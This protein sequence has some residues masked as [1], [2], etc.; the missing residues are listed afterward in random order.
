MNSCRAWLRPSTRGVQL[1]YIRGS[2]ARGPASAPVGHQHPIDYA[3]AENEGCANRQG[4]LEAAAGDRLTCDQR[5]ERDAQ[6][7]CTVIPGQDGAASGW[8]IVGKSG[9]L[10]WEEELSHRRAHT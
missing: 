2:P 9:L 5:A 8:K 1:P 6:K 4:C 7:K 3:T 10:G